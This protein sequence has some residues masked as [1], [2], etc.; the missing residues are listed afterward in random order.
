MTKLDDCLVDA[1]LKHKTKRAKYII[2]LKADVTR[3]WVNGHS[4]LSAGSVVGDREIVEKILENI[5]APR[6]MRNIPT[7][8]SQC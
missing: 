3:G 8:L 5:T 4:S 6:I 7:S 1:I 2:D